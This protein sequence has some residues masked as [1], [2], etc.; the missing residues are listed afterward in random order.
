MKRINKARSFS[1]NDV[2]SLELEVDRDV[3][4]EHSKLVL[5]STVKDRE[6]IPIPVDYSTIATLI[7]LFKD[8]ASLLAQ[9]SSAGLLPKK[10]S[11]KEKDALIERIKMARVWLEKY[12]PQEFKLSFLETLSDEI[13]NAIDSSAKALL[14]TVAKKLA[15]IDSANDLQQ[16]IFEEAKANDVK[17][18]QLFKAI[19]LSLTGKESGPRAGLLIL[20]LGKE[21]CLSRFKELA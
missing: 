2:P 8:D 19:Y 5:Y 16:A 11:G 13:K 21:K 3:S 18:K 14:P 9:L 7:P 4:S 15:G 12:A 10:F 1:W 6:L 17:P 20:A